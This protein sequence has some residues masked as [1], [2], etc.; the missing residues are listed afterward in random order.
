MNKQQREDA[1]KFLSY[2]L[3]HAPQAIGIQLDSEGWTDLDEL[4][5]GSITALPAAS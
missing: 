5:Q 1:S 2:I 3:R 4:I